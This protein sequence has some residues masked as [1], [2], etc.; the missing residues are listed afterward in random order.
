ME[1]EYYY[2]VTG[3]PDP[4]PYSF[5]DEGYEVRTGGNAVITPISGIEITYGFDFLHHTGYAKGVI[6]EIISTGDTEYRYEGIQMKHSLAIGI[7]IGGFLRQQMGIFI[8]GGIQVDNPTGI[9]YSTSFPAFLDWIV[10]V[11]NAVLLWVFSVIRGGNVIGGLED[12][13]KI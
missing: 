3:D 8:R 2:P 4:T 6:N 10:G 5:E 11:A 9:C 13:E 12:L 1:G 7:D